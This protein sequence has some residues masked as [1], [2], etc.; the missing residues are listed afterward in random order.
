MDPIGFSLN[1]VQIK[2][3]MFVFESKIKGDNDKLI[4]PKNK[5]NFIGK[6]DDTVLFNFSHIIFPLKYPS[7]REASLGYESIMHTLCSPQVAQTE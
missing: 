4:V 1:S 5:L 6:K 2:N 3:D 7:E